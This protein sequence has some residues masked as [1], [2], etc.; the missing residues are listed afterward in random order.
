MI[1]QCSNC[2]SQQDVVVVPVLERRATMSSPA[3][4]ADTLICE[5]CLESPEPDEAY[6]R[7]A[8]QYDGEGKDWR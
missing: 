7:A 8:A 6:E 2:G 5:S 1:P 3:E 4:Y